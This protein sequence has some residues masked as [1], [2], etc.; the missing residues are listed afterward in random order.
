MLKRKKNR[1]NALRFDSTWVKMLIAFIT[2]MFAS[3]L[4]MFVIMTKNNQKNQLAVNRGIIMRQMITIAEAIA[5]NPPSRRLDIVSAINIPDINVRPSKRPYFHLQATT[6]D[7]W[8][9]T[10]KLKTIPKEKRSLHISIKLGPKAWLNISGYMDTTSAWRLQLFLLILELIIAI[11]IGFAIWAANHYN[12]SLTHFVQDIE[13]LS[14][15]IAGYHLA[16]NYG[17]EAVR[18]AA[19]AINKMQKRITLLIQTRTQILAAISHDLR[20]PL[21]RL[22]LR[23][24][25]LEDT[26]SREKMLHD[27]DEMSAMITES[28]AYSK[29]EDHQFEMIQTDL[30]AVLFDTCCAYQETGKNVHYRGPQNGFMIMG[31]ALALKRALNNIIDNGLNYATKVNVYLRYQA[32]HYK[33]LID[34]NGPGIPKEERE[35][36]FRPFYR[37]EKSRSRATGGTG[38]GLAAVRSI[39]IAHAG[40]ITLEENKAG[41]LRAVIKL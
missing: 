8:S 7:V 24:Q 23:C 30:A 41:G 9:I 17:P 35:K 16:E 4:I 40:E 6:F 19:H 36:V 21:T 38:L 22:K 26:L 39:I 10:K 1:R 25:F 18:Q 37:L 28:I 15:N 33:I 32:D 29:D 20:T 14:R 12:K 11:A 3:H 13:S 5:I 31:N 27:I 34:D 2:V